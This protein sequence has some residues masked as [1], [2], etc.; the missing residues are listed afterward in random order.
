MSPDEVSTLLAQA[1][2]LFLFPGMSGA[3]AIG[4]RVKGEGED[5]V[6]EFGARVN[7]SHAMVPLEIAFELPL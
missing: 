6:L 1:A 3:A 5:R 7:P 2:G 4:A